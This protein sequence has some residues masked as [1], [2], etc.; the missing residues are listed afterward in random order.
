MISVLESNAVLDTARLMNRRDALR[1]DQEIEAENKENRCLRN[2]SKLPAHLDKTDE[3]FWA[4]TPGITGAKTSQ[5]EPGKKGG[6]YYS[7]GLYPRDRR[8]LADVALAAGWDVKKAQVLE[9]RCINSMKSRLKEVDEGAG[10]S[11]HQPT[12]DGTPYTFQHINWSQLACRIKR[13]VKE[14]DPTN[15]AVVMAAVLDCYTTN[16][17]TYDGSKQLPPLGPGEQR[18]SDDVPVP[19]SN[20]RRAQEDIEA[21]ERLKQAYR[22]SVHDRKKFMSP[23]R[24]KGVV[25]AFLNGT[26]GRTAMTRQ[27]LCSAMNVTEEE[28]DFFLVERKEKAMLGSKGFH[29]ALAYI[30]DRSTEHQKQVVENRPASEEESPPSG[31][32]AV[33]RSS[34]EP[35]SDA[36]V[37]EVPPPSEQ[38]QSTRGKKRSQP[39]QD[40]QECSV[41]KRTT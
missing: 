16:S 8:I 7:W 32:L 25:K 23:V 30:H 18:V 2:P 10:V 14:I 40:S 26:S 6:S 1:L 19:L 39:T 21:N 28:L 20:I 35:S 34:R 33:E 15:L 5:G 13:E 29:H 41:K 11:G 22:M 31:T 3:K 4:S 38:S 36:S 27:Q 17:K 24:V 9:Q 12:K 37:E